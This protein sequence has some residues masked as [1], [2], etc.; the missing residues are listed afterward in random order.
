MRHGSWPL[1][2]FSL[3]GL[4]CVVAIAPVSPSKP[5]DSRFWKRLSWLS[6]VASCRCGRAI[7]SSAVAREVRPP[8]SMCG[9]RSSQSPCRRAAR[10]HGRRVVESW[11]RSRTA[12]SRSSAPMAWPNR[13][14][15]RRGRAA[16]PCWMHLS[17]GVEGPPPGQAL[18]GARPGA[19]LIGLPAI[20]RSKEPR[21]GW[22]ARSY[23]LDGRGRRPVD[24]GRCAHRL[25]PTNHTHVDDTRGVIAA[26]QAGSQRPRRAP[27]FP[28][29][30]MPRMPAVA[31]R[32]SAISA[33][34]RT[35]AGGGQPQQLELQPAAKSASNRGAELPH[36]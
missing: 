1:T 20:P 6:R 7:E 14:S 13:S 2:L 27:T 8:R 23:R 5:F 33:R 30:A 29:S 18:R 32:R 36:R 12:R 4:C 25:R 22:R 15:T 34:R 19:D 16:C 17:A 21:A 26:L 24:L 3:M 28:T 35:A 10:A 31:S 9:T 11:T